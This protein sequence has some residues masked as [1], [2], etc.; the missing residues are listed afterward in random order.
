MSAGTTNACHARR[1]SRR[2]PPARR[3]GRRRSRTTRCPAAPTVAGA[4][5][6]RPAGDARVPR[7]RLGSGQ[8]ERPRPTLGRHRRRGTAG[9]A[10]RHRSRRRPA[11]TAWWSPGTAWGRRRSRAAR[12]R[13]PAR[14]RRRRRRR[15][16]TGM[17]RPGQSSAHEVSHRSARVVAVVDDGA[18]VRRRAL[19]GQDL[20][21]CRSG[22]PAGPRRTRSPPLRLPVLRMVLSKHAKFPLASCA[23]RTS[24]G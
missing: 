11:R 8:R 5:A 20:G 13:S 17:A 16:S 7:V 3:P 24:E 1:R 4:S 15:A 14:R 6:P 22:G 2:A 23:H 12:A 21:R 10:R 9:A 19:L 18:Q